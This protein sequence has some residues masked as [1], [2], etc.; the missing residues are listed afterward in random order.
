MDDWIFKIK[1]LSS[2]KEAE[3]SRAGRPRPKFVVSGHSVSGRL[4]ADPVDLA[5]EL[6]GSSGNAHPVVVSLV[7]SR[8]PEVEFFVYEDIPDELQT[9]DHQ[10]LYLR[11]KKL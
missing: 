3:G 1:S 7:M 11:I 4:D 2:L 9:L 10:D 8:K 5:C 6:F